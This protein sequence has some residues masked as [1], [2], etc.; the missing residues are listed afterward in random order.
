[1]KNETKKY[2]VK[3]A[4]QSARKLSIDFDLYTDGDPEFKSELI[5]LMLDNIKE[6]QQSLNNAKENNDAEIFRKTCHKIKP[7]LS[8]IDDA[9]FNDIIEVLKCQINNQN[10]ITVFNSLSNMVLKTLEEEMD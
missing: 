2:D 1:M 8:M 7:T 3:T 5:V 9:E 4:S 10:C 6:L